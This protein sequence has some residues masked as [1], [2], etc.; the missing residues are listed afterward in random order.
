MCCSVSFCSL[1]AEITCLQSV[2]TLENKQTF[3]CF[4]Q[5]ALRQALEQYTYE[6]LWQFLK[7]LPSALEACAVRPHREYRHF[8]IDELVVL[9]A[10]GA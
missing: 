9:P 5:C 7:A 1:A 6:Q 4:S 10:D 3:R 8:R 2:P